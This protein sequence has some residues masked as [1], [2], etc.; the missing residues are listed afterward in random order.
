MLLLGR[1]V[2]GRRRNTGAVGRV[3][4][5]IYERENG[6]GLKFL[7]VIEEPRDRCSMTAVDKSSNID[8]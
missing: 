4:A 2:T 6:Y 7:P 1:L 3:A 5:S 8:L